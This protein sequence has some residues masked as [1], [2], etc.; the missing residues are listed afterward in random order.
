MFLLLV[1]A[2]LYDLFILI[3]TLLVQYFFSHIGF[4]KITCK[5]N[6][7]ATYADEMFMSVCAI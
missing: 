4:M 2:A 5:H 7:L 1:V 6:D 3:F